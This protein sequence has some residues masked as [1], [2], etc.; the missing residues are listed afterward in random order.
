MTQ[1]MN[2]RFTIVSNL[3][4]Q[5]G[6]YF[7]FNANEKKARDLF[8]TGRF[9]CFLPLSGENIYVRNASNDNPLQ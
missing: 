9:L 8:S 6:H 2:K 4:E 3:M 5:N 7:C 1:I